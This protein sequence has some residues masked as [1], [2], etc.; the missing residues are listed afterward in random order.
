MPRR[1]IVVGKNSLDAF[2][3]MQE[4]PQLEILSLT[5]EQLIELNL[6]LDTIGKVYKAIYRAHS[7]THNDLRT[8][9]TV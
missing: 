4:N 3:I 2:R 7:L 8:V 9:V 1:I 6:K 5:P